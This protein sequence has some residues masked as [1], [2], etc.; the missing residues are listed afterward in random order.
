MPRPV[1]LLLVVI[2]AAPASAA[3][4]EL[5]AGNA[6][7][8]TRDLTMSA[9]G[10]L[11]V[12]CVMV[13]GFRYAALVA[14]DGHGPHVPAFAADARWKTLEPH[15]APGTQRLFFA[16]D[17]GG[18]GREDLWVVDYHWQDERVVWGE[19]RPL[20]PPINTDG[21]EFF[22]SLTRDGTLYFN[23]RAVGEPVE[24]IMRARPDGQ[25]GWLQPEPL[26]EAVNTGTTR[27]NAFVDPDERYVIV[28]VA[29]HPE[30]LGQ[31]DYWIAFRDQD[32][33]WRGPV[34]LGAEV[35]GPGREGW[36]PYV[37]PDGA[38]IYF[39]SARDGL[40]QEAPLTYERLLEMHASPGNGL[41][42]LWR[43]PAGFLTALAP[44]SP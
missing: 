1:I 9:D 23:R 4:A 21:S 27:F 16:S 26:P 35:N 28:C 20:G 38:W 44:R 24:Q 30:N 14:D 17:R 40:N 8:R 32:D 29:G 43:L 34:N 12:Y 7:P 19:P 41:G 15:L 31:V 2:L 3:T 5:W 11:S 33:Q 10:R 36:S 22:P 37:S 18:S 39:M 13:G 25:G 42:H 6:P